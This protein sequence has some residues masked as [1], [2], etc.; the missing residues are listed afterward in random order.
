[1]T[2]VLINRKFGH[3][4]TRKEDIVKTERMSFTS[5]ETCKA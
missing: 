1:M 3:R 4:H 5:E 2:C